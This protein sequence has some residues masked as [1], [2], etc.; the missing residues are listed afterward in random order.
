MLVKVC[1]ISIEFNTNLGEVNEAARRAE[2]WN[3]ISKLPDGMQ[4]RVGDR[5]HQLSGGQKQ[6]VGEFLS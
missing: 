2:A 4:T 1:F 5:G 6:R 3:F